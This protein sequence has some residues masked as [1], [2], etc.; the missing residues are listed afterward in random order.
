MSACGRRPLLG[1]P[2]DTS[3]R[4]KV[5][6]SS[7]MRDD[8]SERAEAEAGGL[9][10]ASAT[11]PA[12]SVNRTLL[13]FLG[14]R[15]PMRR[16][17]SETGP[18]AAGG[19]WGAAA[20][21]ARAR[22]TGIQENQLLE[23]G[24]V[25]AALAACRGRWQGQGRGGWAGAARAGE[26]SALQGPAQGAAGQGG[27]RGRTEPGRAGR[28]VALPVYGS[29][30]EAAPGCMSGEPMRCMSCEPMRS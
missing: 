26:P 2:I 9:P 30:A 20:G 8:A 10:D 29:G 18:L 4:L 6:S 21:E 24:G 16:V 14:R 17:P 27:G 22:P 19:C 3:G 12:G 5:L 23:W 15:A 11:G 1:S 28:T 7:V 25:E 13:G